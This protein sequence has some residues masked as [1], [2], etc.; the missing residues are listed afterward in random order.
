M[1]TRSPYRILLWIALPFIVS[2]VLLRLLIPAQG[3]WRRG[4]VDS[5]SPEIPAFMFVGSSRVAASIDL[6]SFVSALPYNFRDA[7]QFRNLGAGYTSLGTHYFKLRAMLQENPNLLRNGY[8]VIEAPG[9][10]PVYEPVS[11]NWCHPEAPMLLSQS[12][13]TAYLGDFLTQ[14]GNSWQNKLIVSALRLSATCYIIY[15]AHLFAQTGFESV[16]Q[17][18]FHRTE[19]ASDLYQTGGIRSD[20]TS[21]RLARELALNQAAADAKDTSPRDNWEA[22]WFGRLVALVQSAGG[23]IIVYS[24]P[25]SNPFIEALEKPARQVDIATFGA[26]AARNGILVSDVGLQMDDN[27]FPD[28]IHVRSSRAPEFSAALATAIAAHLATTRDGIRD[29]VDRP[30]SE[31]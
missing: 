12:L 9:G 14:A 27:D 18:I 17:A 30:S 5:F 31:K 6:A 3:I 25:V 19:P 21:V 22:T 28:L 2:E 20:P 1:K 23:Q 24:M 11:G 26:Y 4:Y 13:P 16:L 15:K 7:Y 8:V 10:L 29:S